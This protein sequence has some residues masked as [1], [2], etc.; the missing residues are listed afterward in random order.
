[1]STLLDKAIA[2]GLVLVIVFTALA[3]GVVEPWSFFLLELITVVLVMMWVFKALLD[4][5]LTLVIPTTVW[6]LAALILFGLAQ[7]VAWTDAAGNR[8]SLSFDVEATRGTVIVLCSLLALSLLAANFLTGARRL[9]A[10][11]KFLIFFGTA[12]GVFGL[13]QHFSG[14][15]SV[16]WLRPANESP[17]GPFFNRDHFAGYMELFIA[18]PVALIVTGYVRGEERMIYGVATMLMGVAAIF[19]LSRAGMISILAEMIFLAAMGIRH[20]QITRPNRQQVKARMVASVAAVG[21]ILAAIVAGVIWI[22]AEPII[23]RIVTGDP[24]SSDLS[25][26]QTF[27]SIRGALWE[28]TWPTFRHN[29]LTGVGLGAFETAYPM[30]ARYNGM[31]GILAQAHNDYLQ[32]LIDAGVIGAALTLW[33]LII[34]FREIARGVRSPNP[35]MAAIAIGGGAGLFGLLVHSFFD[36]NLHLPSHAALFLFLSMMVSHVASTIDKRVED[37]AT[38]SLIAPFLIRKV[39]S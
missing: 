36:F 16:Y 14:S 35:L 32:V 2:I 39:S 29:P 30:Y 7:S 10:T 25:K 23:N 11:T 3:H 38:P 13:I 27:Y 26:A 19:T 21:V 17:F 33:F 34:L 1:M 12:I 8:Q 37:R 24:N 15:T 4:K 22:G 20:Y 31:Q 9:R 28:E 6:P 5:D 18:L